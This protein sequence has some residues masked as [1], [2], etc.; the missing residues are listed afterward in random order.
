[1]ADMKFK[2]LLFLFIFAL[3]S[4]SNKSYYYVEDNKPEQ[5]IE[6]G[7]DS[8]AYMR[9]FQI[10]VISKKAYAKMKESNIAQYLNAPGEFHL[11]NQDRKDITNSVYFSNK[12]SLKQDCIARVNNL[13]TTS[14]EQTAKPATDGNQTRGA[15][16]DTAGLYLAMVKILSAK[17]VT[18]EYSNYKDIQLIYKNTGNKKIS[19]IRFKWYGENA[20]NEPAD[21]GGLKRGW[22]TGFVDD[23]LRAGKTDSGSWNILSRDGKKILIAY[24]YEIAFEDGTKWSL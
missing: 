21:M 19:A 18:K 1:M 15:K 17:F 7:S 8:A 12:E 22:G 10:F 3:N 2:T 14:L 9:A 13:P 6:S 11:L 16:Y 24:P 20:F 4:C 23:G 5:V